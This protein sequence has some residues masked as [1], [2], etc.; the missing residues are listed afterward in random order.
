MATAAEY[1]LII[2]SKIDA[3]VIQDEKHAAAAADDATAS[4]TEKTYVSFPRRTHFEFI[5]MAPAKDVLAWKSCGINHGDASTFLCPCTAFMTA[6][7]E[8]ALLDHGNLTLHM[9]CK[10][11]PFIAH[12]P[13]AAIKEGGYASGTQLTFVAPHTVSRNADDDSNYTFTLPCAHTDDQ[14]MAIYA[15]L[16]KVKTH[17]FSKFKP[18]LHFK[19]GSRLRPN[20]EDYKALAHLSFENI[21]FELARCRD[22]YD[23]D[24]PESHDHRFVCENVPGNRLLWQKLLELYTGRQPDFTFSELVE[25]TAIPI[26]RAF[27]PVLRQCVYDVLSVDNAAGALKHDGIVEWMVDGT[28]KSFK[29]R[30]LALCE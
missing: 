25:L 7:H 3:A 14:F 12:V 17:D 20:V 8:N 28:E 2:D 27:W 9:S 5:G 10:H 24:V 19:D 16:E 22:G 26:A 29:M 6:M 18:C 30:C 11:R 15:H 4:P 1:R 21:D 23:D 13:A